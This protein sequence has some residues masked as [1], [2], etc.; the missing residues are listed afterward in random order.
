M[1]AAPH[2]DVRTVVTSSMPSAETMEEVLNTMPTEVGGGW[3]GV[4]VWMRG[5]GGGGSAGGN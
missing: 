1:M 3:E 5:R 4:R 2:T